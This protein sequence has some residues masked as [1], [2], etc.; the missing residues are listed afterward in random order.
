[1]HT[2]IY[3]VKMIYRYTL[4]NAVFY[5]ESLLRVHAASQDEATAH[6]R[7]YAS[8]FV[9]RTYTNIE[10]ETVTV[11]L[12]DIADCCPVKTANPEIEE[13]YAGVFRNESGLSEE[14]FLELRTDTCSRE[15][16]KPLRHV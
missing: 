5:E 13:V 6:A 14:E 16:R 3:G 8:D 7:N 9:E 15:E 11:R 12:C 2:E 4:P 1:M 10:G